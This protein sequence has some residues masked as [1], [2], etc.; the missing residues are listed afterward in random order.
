MNPDQF[1]RHSRFKQR[2]DT[3]PT[4]PGV[5]IMHDKTGAIIY[6][7]KAVNLRNR[8]R[9]Y[10]GSLSGAAPKVGRMV[11]HIED[12]EYILTDT[13]LEALIL[14][15]QLIK[16]HKPH[17]NVRL[18][19]D[20]TYPYIRV[21]VQ[22]VWPRVMYTR[23]LVED[24]SRYFGPFANA[25]AVQ[26]TLD[27]LNRLFP[28]RTCDLT[29]DGKMPR[30]CLQYYMHRCLAPCAGLADRT[31]Y[32]KAIS[33]VV[34]FL[35]GKQATIVRDL[36][37]RMEAA[38]ENLEFERAA[39]LRDQIRAIE[40]TTESQ[41]VFS[42]AATDEDVIAFARNDGDACVQ[43]FFIRQG[44]LLGSERYVLE[45]TGDAE[46]GEV[47]GSF[48]SQFYED[49]TDI[50]PNLLLQHD[51]DETAILE[52][53]LRQKRG[54]KVQLSVPRRG[55]K[56]DLVELVARNATECVEQMR[57][58]W[59]SDEQKAVAALGDLQNALTLEAW[60]QRIE[61]YDI[62]HSQGTNTVASMVVFEHG[63]P[64]KKEYRRFEI[65]TATNNDFLSMQEVLRRRFRRAG[66]ER[67]AQVAAQPTPS[68]VTLAPSLAAL[69]EAA[70][71]RA[72]DLS[73]T[74]SPMKGG[75]LDD[76]RADLSPDP[77]PTKGGEVDDLRAD[78]SPDPSPTKGG[79]VGGYATDV[80]NEY[81]NET[82]DTATPPS[83]VGKGVG[84]L[85]PS[86]ASDNPRKEPL[87]MFYST[88][89]GLGPSR[90]SDNAA[91]ATAN[92]ATSNGVA[93]WSGWAV[94][95]DLIII[96]GGKGQLSA[97]VEVM[98][99]VKLAQIPII[100]LAKQQ[101][102]VFKPSQSIGLLLPRESE[103]LHLLQRI[104]DEAHRFAIGYHRKL[105]S[106][107]AFKGKLDE[108]PG[109]GPRRKTELLKHFGSLKK[110]REA[111]IE[112]L[113]AVP[114]MDRRAAQKLKDLL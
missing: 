97:A 33:D 78:L 83:F 38:A 50:P 29:I 69:Q 16:K 96:D 48:I 22:E 90:A 109:I 63:I 66:L 60:P 20:K 56:H 32:S 19:D 101:E 30:P 36:T 34:L 112:E 54:D 37:K 35:E 28:Y 14:E 53:W 92:A 13:E 40:K 82:S 87:P 102:E 17:Y 106:K 26:T 27:L 95:P 58:R 59:L 5:Y 21:T 8:V 72:S 89:G 15:N 80:L 25:G 108:I 88:V 65:K 47:M 12:F 100:G 110:M 114:G 113:A 1:D 62:S 107:R 91:A 46:P 93:N 103:G 39:Y 75:E 7:G 49:S 76:L 111:T 3:L 10:F 6:V 104:R 64:A 86:R 2:L 73:P 67:A 52:A 9:S 44:K 71:E 74:P 42:T 99:E 81:G 43:V 11:S 57:Q 23:R 98:A 79:E 70:A 94:L 41:K 105:R 77:S 24:G 61:C 84:G 4:T 51:A 68:D 85:G 18:K 55:E 45:N 31:D